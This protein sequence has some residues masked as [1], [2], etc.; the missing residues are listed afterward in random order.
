MGQITSGVGLI[1]GIN[2][3]QLIDQL[4]ALEAR[5][6]R[7][8]EQRNTVL[9]TQQVAFQ[10]I[11][12]KLLAL[13][14]SANSFTDQQIFQTTSANSSNEDVLTVSS[15]AGAVP[16]SYDFVVDKLVTSQ[17]VI[18]KGF[19]DL[20]Q[21]P[22]APDGGTLTFEFG[23]SRLDSDTTLNDL[24]GGAGVNRGKIRITD[25][26]GATAV[27]DLSKALSVN[28]VLDAINNTSG[29]NVAASVD[30]E[31]F[32]IE[33]L[34]GLT[35]VA[36]SVTDVG[37]T[38]TATS[39][40]LNV[41]SSGNTLTG[42][43]VVQLGDDFLLSKLN[44]GNG[45]HIRSGQ[46]VNDFTVTRRDGNSFD[47]DL[48]G[49]VTVGDVIQK[50]HAASG[51]DVTASVNQDGTGL[52]LVDTTTGGGT[53]QVVAIGTSKAAEDLGILTSDQDD[54]GVID[55]QRVI[56]G[57]NSKLLKNL[58]GGDGV[59]VTS[60]NNTLTTQTKLSDLFQGAGI[61][62]NGNPALADLAVTD[63]S[64]ASYQIELDNLTTV[65]DLIDAFDTATSG[66]VTLDINGQT[67]RATN[68]AVGLSNF[69]IQDINGS[70]AANE[71]GIEANFT[72]SDGNTVTGHD[73]D[74]RVPATVDVTN[75]DGNT[76]TIDVIG[77][78]TVED[79]L[80]RINGAGAG[81]VASLNHAGNGLII[82]DTTGGSGDLTLSGTLFDG[83]NLSGTYDTQTVADS[84]NLQF[85]Y[86]S[87]ATTLSSLNGGLGVAS[88]QFRITDSSGVSAIVDLRQ[89]ET[90]IQ[91]VISDINSRGLKINA[92]IND[93][94]DGI[95]IEDTNSAVP[96]RAIQVEEVG[97]TTA[98]DLN[99]LG[100]AQ[101]PGDD[102]D[103]SFETTI[104]IQS[105][106]DL[107]TSTSLTAL[108]G[109]QGV[110]KVSGQ[111]EFRITTRDGT[112]HN[113]NL[114]NT[115]TVDDVINAI[116][117]DTGGSVT[118]SINSQTRSLTLT[119]H[120]SGSEA[121]SIRSLNAS[122]AAADL[123]LL[124]PDDDEDGVITGSAI[125][126]I[127]TLENLAQ[128]IN[129]AGIPV[130]ASVINDG[131]SGRPFRLS[132]N[133][134]RPGRSGAFQ[135]DDGGLGFGAATLTE[136][137]DAVVFFGSADPAKAI[138]ITSSNNALDSVIPNASIDLINTSESPV[139]VTISNDSSAITDAVSSFVERFNDVVSTIDDLDSFDAETEQRGLLLGDP[140]VA[141][142]RS[143]LFRLVNN[144]NNDLT[145]QFSTLAQVG[146][147]VG[148]GA[149]LSFDE[150]KF[151]E[152]LEADPTG[153]EQLFTL[154]QTELDEDT[155]ETI[156]VA[157]GIGV[158]ID[159][160]LDRLSDPNSG[161][162][163]SRLDSIDRQ[164]ELGN[165][166][167]DQ[168][169]EQ[170]EAKRQRLEAEFL[171]MERVLAQ[172]QNQSSALA[173]FQPVSPSASLPGL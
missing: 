11:N 105:V 58:N 9:T 168:I 71:L 154:K 153:V 156:T 35:N 167:I 88:G 116:S 20:D 8:V 30:G 62:P 90:T 142:I 49:A 119:D 155:N 68:N 148:N 141:Q 143:S 161:V 15:S 2:T 159:E 162:V 14:L 66:N 28:E 133:A 75:R 112:E 135:F 140:T 122:N 50:I 147:R 117:N 165:R 125:V 128:K 103:G 129:D 101:N 132:L 87:E 59:S 70:T 48:T 31:G 136:A 99:L 72:L 152:A 21:S 33:D 100:Q 82:T 118:A 27:V 95:L 166:R 98:A 23:P 121:F 39:L 124:N 94:G 160:L 13:K 4:L 123:G 164:I 78:Q 64:G 45:V 137:K 7:L 18:T 96:T 173:G 113:I 150:S 83:F 53:L 32:K 16:G 157:A 55:G 170:I 37:D 10:D 12:A 43:Q 138:A 149:R 86:I 22:I 93:H 92:R 81:V 6:K 60:A 51:G 26:S 69:Q 77:S 67:L 114:D 106:L 102:L 56:A 110:D 74:P 91:D 84:G 146:V 63:R 38:E 89:G 151:R 111:S 1:S 65:Q 29:I 85:R 169:D 130:T 3:A 144:R 109:G 120:T 24:N 19:T 115:V 80:D 44:D 108:N 73:T 107:E 127:V 79:V 17:Q 41:A 172:L 47:V 46:N 126:E 104:A 34:S 36:L 145:G 134:D 42:S 25:R 131:S 5:P 52:Q 54:D 139:R 171:A 76:F 40:G 57:L 61:T 158:R 97:S 163:Q